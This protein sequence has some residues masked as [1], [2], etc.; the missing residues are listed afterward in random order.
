MNRRRL[1]TGSITPVWLTLVTATLLLLILFVDQ[2]WANYQ[3]RKAQ[4][5][6]DFAAEAGA[7]TAQ[8]TYRLWVEGQQGTAVSVPDPNC[9]AGQ[10]CPLITTWTY[11]SWSNTCVGTLE[12]LS[13]S[14]WM[15]HCGCT[16]ASAQYVVQCLRVR[17]LSPDVQWPA[18]VDDTV[19]ATF[20]ANWVDRPN[21]RVTATYPYQDETITRRLSVLTVTLRITSLFGGTWWTVT[22][23]PIIGLST[24][25]IPPLRLSTN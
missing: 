5:T 16:T 13:G 19:T 15:S 8:I 23:R 24:L 17:E 10:P 1:Q 12:A 25:K 14:G 20:N 9:V 18:N 7:A 11:S 21:S 2:E 4:Q 22:P 6:A 3:I